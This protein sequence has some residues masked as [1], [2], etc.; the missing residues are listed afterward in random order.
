VLQQVLRK[1]ETDAVDM[2][3]KGM[4][5]SRLKKLHAMQSFKLGLTV[6]YKVY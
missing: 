2:K 5:F 1:F 4:C 3:G 6:F